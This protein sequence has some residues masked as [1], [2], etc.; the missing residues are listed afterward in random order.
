MGSP[1]EIAHSRGGE[2]MSTPRIQVLIDDVDLAPEVLD[3]LDLVGAAV[4]L[5][6]LNLD[7]PKQADHAA[8]A[9]L[10]VTSDSHDE[11]EF[12]KGFF[13]QLITGFRKSK[14]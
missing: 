4:E 12:P 14:K 10:V 6:R 2:L 7:E 11:D 5:R 1:A 3:A 8:D 9:R 13:G